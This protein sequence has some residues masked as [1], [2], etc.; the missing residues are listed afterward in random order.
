M[1]C[2]VHVKEG[3]ESAVEDFVVRLLSGK[4]AV[5]CFHLTRSRKKKFK[6]QWQTV[7]EELFPG[8]VFVETDQPENVY[9]ELKKVPRPRLLFS[10][11]DYVSRLEEQETA[12][13]EMIS[14]KNGLIG[15][16]GVHVAGDGTIRFLSGP[17]AKVKNQVKKVNLH[18]RVA[19]LETSF[20]GSR[21]LLYL[22]IEIELNEGS[23][24]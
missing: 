14:D 8:Y 21:R 5:R 23:K 4:Q 20:L 11:D 12:L 22:G 18:K 15:I 2:A 10:D 19:E 16:S 3:A 6:G 7:Y 17:L 24:A 9:R 1:W 13:M